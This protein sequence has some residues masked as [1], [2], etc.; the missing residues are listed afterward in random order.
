M[1]K[2]SFSQQAA[3]CYGVNPAMILDYIAFFC[4]KNRR[5]GAK[6]V[7]G[8]VWTYAS[9]S[10]INKSFTFF[11]ARQIRTAIQHLVK[12]NA[13][14]VSEHNQKGYDRTKWYTPT[15]EGWL[16]SSFDKYVKPTDINDKPIPINNIKERIPVREFQE[17]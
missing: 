3:H 13:I 17:I 12:R 2:I 6:E 8:E 5:I 11:S 4:F 10:H 1:K 9:I 14:L 16:N 15:A 7:D